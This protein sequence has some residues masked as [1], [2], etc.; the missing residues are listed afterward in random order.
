M[1]ANEI[2][3]IIE[4]L[5]KPK[6]TNVF[7]DIKEITKFMDTYI[8]DFWNENKDKYID[9]KLVAIIASNKFFEIQGVYFLEDGVIICHN[10][11]S[12]DEITVV[13]TGAFFHNKKFKDDY[14][15]CYGNDEVQMLLPRD[16][17]TVFTCD[18]IEKI[19]EERN[20]IYNIDDKIKYY[21]NLY[22]QMERENP[23]IT[24]HKV[25]LY[26]KI[27]QMTQNPDLIG[28]LVEI[29]GFSEYL[30]KYDESNKKRKLESY[31]TLPL[32][33]LGRTNIFTAKKANEAEINRYCKMYEN[34]L[35]DCYPYLKLMQDCNQIEGY[36]SF[37][38]CYYDMLMY[39]SQIQKKLSEELI[40]KF[41]LVVDELRNKIED[42]IINISQ[43][44]N[45]NILSM[46][47]CI[48]DVY[49]GE[50]TF[51]KGNSKNKKVSKYTFLKNSD[52]AYYWL[53]LYLNQTGSDNTAE[54]EDIMLH[55]A[56]IY[57]YGTGTMP[58][59][60]N[61][62]LECLKTAAGHGCAKATKFIAEHYIKNNSEEKYK[63]IQLA[64]ENGQK[65]NDKRSIFEKI[66]I[67][68]N[69]IFETLESA[70][71]VINNVTEITNTV[72]DISGDI[73]D[74]YRNS[75]LESLEQEQLLEGQIVENKKAKAKNMKAERKA[76]KAIAREEKKRNKM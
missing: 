31:K 28:K 57:N 62:M 13:S 76:D 33:T 59:D 52:K 36:K 7:Y 18:V 49:F 35:L 67:G 2:K 60:E 15:I 42:D 32:E 56:D 14:F 74:G 47:K 50:I 72:K 27:T 54:Y 70:N 51:Y 11:I 46:I 65:I 20:R 5:D 63:W 16:K 45:F 3:K 34:I 39:A 29:Y 61:K 66:G 69:D 6:E 19:I 48:S 68:F 64:K 17:T 23:E 21:L 24:L 53:N 75:K 26:K 41:N 44:N 30:L 73:V 40:Y 55:L 12:Y 4:G 1:T 38:S 25:M 10:Y 58:A 22:N 8:V 43:E 71:R 37:V 9:K